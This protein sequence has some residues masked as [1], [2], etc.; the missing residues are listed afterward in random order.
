MHVYQVKLMNG[1]QKLMQLLSYKFC[2]KQKYWL[3]WTVK[4][5]GKYKMRLTEETL[6]RALQQWN[7]VTKNPTKGS[8]DTI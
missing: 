2:E 7:S 6:V 1:F 5:N 4:V 3:L 8:S